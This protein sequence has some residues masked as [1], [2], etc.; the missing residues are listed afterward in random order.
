MCRCRLH[1]V[2]C[3][4]L[5]ALLVGYGAGDAAAD[6]NLYRGQTIVT[7]QGEINRHLGFAACLDDVIVKVSGLLRLAGDPRLDRHKASAASLVRDYSY[8][9]EKGGKPKN[10]EQG[11]R[12][13]SFV[14]TAD[15]DEVGVNRI[16]TSL[17]VRPWLAPRPVLG[18]FVEMD[19][20]AR[21]MIVASD[22]HQVELH[23]QA[24]L[25]AASKRG[26]PVVL[27]D[28]AALVGLTADDLDPAK[29]SHPKLAA[30]SAMRGGEAVLLARLIWDERA[31]HWNA[32]WQLEWQGRVERWQLA[33]VTFD[34]AFR[35]GIGSAAQAIAERQ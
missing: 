21:R 16:L 3:T 13:R 5:V 12:D 33:A 32:Q 10:D 7:G 18:V 17:G 4:V 1:S 6:N 26:M 11:T 27:P 30:I 28:V 19:P 34:E 35:L 22:S 2:I 9:D 23:R 14:L 20:G 15:F 8:R 24:L 29:A 31:L 25:A